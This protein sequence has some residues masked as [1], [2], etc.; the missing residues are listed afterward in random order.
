MSMPEETFEDD[1]EKAETKKQLKE[2]KENER[3]AMT[4]AKQLQNIYEGLGV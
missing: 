4:G 3:L 1:E 2:L